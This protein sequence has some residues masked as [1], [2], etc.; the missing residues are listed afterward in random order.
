MSS[1]P[2]DYIGLARYLKGHI[3]AEQA[4]LGAYEKILKGREDDMIGYVL[5]SILSDEVRHHEVF[6][7]IANS[8]ESR[9]R[10]DDIEPQLPPRPRAIKDGK[11]LL[12]ATDRLLELE[13]EDIKELQRLRKSWQKA[14]GDLAVWAVLVEGAEYD[15]RKHIALLKHL[16]HMILQAS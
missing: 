6:T 11:A 8:L 1:I 7:E 2:S 16:R 9:I 15:T 10:W 3:D 4:A 13:E 12:D 14:E 5:R